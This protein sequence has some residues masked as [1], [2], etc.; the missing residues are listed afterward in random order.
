MKIIQTS[1]FD[2]ESQ[3]DVLICENVSHFYG[4][5]I[6]NHLIDKYSGGD[7]PN[8]YKMVEEDYI[9]YEFKA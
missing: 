4:E 5:E 1:N 8:F 7:S 6:A 9:L 3:S 2:N